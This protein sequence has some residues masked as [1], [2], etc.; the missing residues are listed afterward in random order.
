MN[1]NE[2]IVNINVQIKMFFNRWIQFTEPFHKLT[3][4]QQLVVSALLYQHYK[5]GKEV[6]NNKILWRSV[7]DYDT[8]LLIAEELN[9]KLSSLENIF[10]RL[11]VLKVIV[12]NRLHPSYIPKI[13]KNFK[14]FKLIFNFNIVK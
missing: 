8:K 12:D 5:I 3:N 6:T 14:N 13:D 1:N 11:R 4:Q 2:T 10:T 7:F 9:I